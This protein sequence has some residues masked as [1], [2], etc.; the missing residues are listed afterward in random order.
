MVEDFTASH[1]P[2]SVDGCSSNV[3]TLFIFCFVT[4]NDAKY[5]IVHK[6]TK[7]TETKVQTQQQQNLSDTKVFSRHTIKTK[8][9]YH[10]K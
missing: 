5:R 4:E 6:H 10:L 3:L 9:A 2:D 8:T 7:Y 1:F